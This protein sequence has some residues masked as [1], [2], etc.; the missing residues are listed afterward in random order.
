[1]NKL[2]TDI[3]TSVPEA[4]PLADSMTAR[5]IFVGAVGWTAQNITAWLQLDQSTAVTIAAGIFGLVTFVGALVG[6]MRRKG[7]KVPSWLVDLLESI[8]K[9]DNKPAT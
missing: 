3:V 7:I 4:K 9:E 1:M 5:W 2:I 8:A 6:T